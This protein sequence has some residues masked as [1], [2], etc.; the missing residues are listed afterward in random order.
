MI[1]IGLHSIISQKLELF[2]KDYNKTDHINLMIC[3]I[4]SVGT[5]A[6]LAG[7]FMFFLFLMKN[8]VSIP[9]LGNDHFLP[10]YFQFIIHKSQYHSVLYNLRY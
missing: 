4:I 1:F 8:S 3:T 9:R 7:F 10:N 6:I 5:Q 2:G